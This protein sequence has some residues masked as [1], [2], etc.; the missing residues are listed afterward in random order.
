MQALRHLHWFN[1]IVVVLLFVMLQAG[2]PA[3]AASKVKVLGAFSGVKHIG[4]DA[5]GYTVQLWQEGDRIFGLLLVYTGAFSDPPTGI[6]EDVK[7]DP[8]TRRFSFTTR[9]STGLVYSQKYRGVPA[10]DR[11]K[12]EG[13]LTRRQLTGIL[14][15]TDDLSP[16]E[17]PTSKRIRLRWSAFMTEVMLPPPATYA[18]WKTEADEMLQRSG[19]KW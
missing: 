3:T 19:P 5:F 16:E 15:H 11:F 17:R 12:F 6:L 4:D 14:S 13:V 1:R 8:R 18:A 9:A 7:F 2:V 10:R